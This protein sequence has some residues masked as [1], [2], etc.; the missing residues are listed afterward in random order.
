MTGF[1]SSS[2]LA[3]CAMPVV[4]KQNRQIKRYEY[5]GNTIMHLCYN[6]MFRIMLADLFTGFAEP[7]FSLLIFADSFIEFF[8]VKIRPKGI[9]KIKFRISTLP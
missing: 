3:S 1:E 4:T 6:L 2:V 5:K 7:A 9:T 8:V